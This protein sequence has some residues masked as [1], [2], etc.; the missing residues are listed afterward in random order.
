M[1]KVVKYFWPPINI[2]GGAGKNENFGEKMVKMVK[3]ASVAI[4]FIPKV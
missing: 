2:V 3:K 1:G 4:F